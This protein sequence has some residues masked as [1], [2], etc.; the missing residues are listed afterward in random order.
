MKKCALILSMIGFGILFAG[1]TIPHYSRT[2]E[3]K[4]DAT[5][6]LVETVVTE[7]VSQQDPNTKPL[8]PALKHQTYQK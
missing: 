7:Y 4:Y 8:L 1:C 2:V 5:G 3:R 6:N